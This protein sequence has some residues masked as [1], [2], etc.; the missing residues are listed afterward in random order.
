MWKEYAMP[1]ETDNKD[2]NNL[3]NPLTGE[4]QKKGDMQYGF[5]YNVVTGNIPALAGQMGLHIGHKIF[6]GLS[7]GLK[8]VFSSDVLQGVTSGVMDT[9]KFAGNKMGQFLGLDTFNKKVESK[10]FET[11][12]M[13]DW[14]Q[15]YGEETK[16]KEGEGE[17]ELTWP[18]LISIFDDVSTFG[19]IRWITDEE[20]EGEEPGV[21]K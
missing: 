3:V 21:G 5:M 16:G 12:E 2:P 15:A 13:Q 4:V 20:R 9:L 10:D 1:F 7:Q 18:Q 11:Q 14:E 8:R 19:A 6:E 17:K